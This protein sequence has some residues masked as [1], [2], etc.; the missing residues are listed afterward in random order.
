MLRSMFYIRKSP[1]ESPTAT[2][3]LAGEAF[4][5]LT[6]TDDVLDAYLNIRE[7]LCEAIEAL[8]DSTP[9]AHTWNF[10]NGQAQASLMK[11]LQGNIDELDELKGHIR[12]SI[13]LMPYQSLSVYKTILLHGRKQ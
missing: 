12:A 2:L 11:F 13:E 1:F 4:S 5:R 6:S 7:T 3:I 10:I 9:Y 8:T